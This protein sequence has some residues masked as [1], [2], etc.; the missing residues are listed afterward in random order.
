MID[1][2]KRKSGELYAEV[3]EDIKPNEFY[4]TGLTLKAR[5]V[6]MQQ[7]SGEIP[8]D[9]AEQIKRRDAEMGAQRGFG[10][11]SMPSKL[12]LRDLG[13]TSL[14]Q[15]QQGLAA[16]M[17]MAEIDVKRQSSEEELRQRALTQSGT[18]QL[19][20]Q[21]LNQKWATALSALG[22]DKA[23]TAQ[24]F[25]ALQS[26]NRNYL[27]ELENQLIV[28][29]A[30]RAIPDF[31]ANLEKLGGTATQPGYFTQIDKEAQKWINM[32]S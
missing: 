5:D 12:T 9:V 11:G 27:A 32:F 31:Q 2:M 10:V 25:L 6:A 17:G 3:P 13:V 1:E 7:L 18:F 26:A 16:A 19:Q 28:S 15:Q 4:E 30:S 22:L 8:D 14:Q 20:T 24:S 23:K 29:N 21:E